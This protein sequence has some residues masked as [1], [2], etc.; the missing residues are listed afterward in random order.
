ME[1]EISSSDMYFGKFTLLDKEYKEDFDK[2]TEKAINNV[3]H[4]K[5]ELQDMIMKQLMNENE[6]T[7]IY[8]TKYRVT[9]GEDPMSVLLEI[10]K[11]R[12]D[13]RSLMWMQERRVEEHV[14]GG[15]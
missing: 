10:F 11:R 2:R 9:N 5:C 14:T 6:I 4:E 15:C 8:E 1:Q 12:E 3:E 13:L 7:L